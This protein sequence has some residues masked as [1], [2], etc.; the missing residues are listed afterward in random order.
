[1]TVAA[2]T[3]GQDV[4]VIGLVGIAHGYSHFYQMILPPV[5][6]LLKAEFDVSFA[7][8][9]LLATVLYAASGTGQLIAG[10]LVDRIGAKPVLLFGLTVC[11]GSTLGFSFA[12]DYQT[13]VVLSLGVGIGMSVFHPA[14][15]SILTLKVNPSRLGR[16]YAVHALCGNLGW[17]VAPPFVVGLTAL[18][19]WRMAAAMAGVVGLLYV[20]LMLLRSRDWAVE[21][22]AVTMDETAEA[23]DNESFAADV[24]LLASAPVVLCFCYFTFFA[25]AM[26]GMQNF[27]ALSLMKLH[28]LPFASATAVLTAF[29]I[30]SAVGV[31]IGGI[32]ADRTPRHHAL[33]MVGTALGSIFMFG[34]ATVSGVAFAVPALMILSGF[35]IGLTMPSR[36]MIVRKVAP[37][38]KTG[39]VFGFVY[40][41]LDLGSLA[42]PV[43]LGWLLD[44]GDP[45]MAMLVVAAVLLVTVATVMQVG[46]RSADPARETA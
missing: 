4:R 39:R 31:F 21:A 25:M 9:G 36:D 34:V 45:K 24:R 22:N 20:A 17:A 15:L 26:V 43:L 46:R 7:A 29:L 16:A 33:A 42:M 23:A 13:L 28:G 41:G 40:A 32:I 6:I 18:Y 10:F 3:L 11:A 1:M 30:A 35:A 44:R 19:D 2:S 8:L 37:E 27:G 12:R 38:G 14:D 5:F